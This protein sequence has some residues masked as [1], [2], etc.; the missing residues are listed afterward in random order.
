MIIDKGKLDITELLKF[1]IPGGIVEKWRGGMV[2]FIQQ[3]EDGEKQYVDLYA[4]LTSWTCIGTTRFQ[5][6]VGQILWHFS[7]AFEK[8]FGKGL[9]SGFA[10]DPD[11]TIV[12]AIW[13]DDLEG[14][15]I[16]AEADKYC[17]KYV[18]SACEVLHLE[19]EFSIATDKGQVC[20]L[21]LQDTLVGADNVVARACPNV[22]SRENKKNNLTMCFVFVGGWVGV[23][24]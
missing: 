16:A 2:D 22:D 13:Q 6:L 24:G 20:R 3:S 7:Q 14:D 11:A 21:P 17:A 18:N 4:L 9:Q 15:I 12:H 19:R 10:E 5:P 23:W 1:A 8:F